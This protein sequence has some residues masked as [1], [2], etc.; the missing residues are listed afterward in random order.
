MEKVPLPGQVNLKVYLKTKLSLEKKIAPDVILDPFGLDVDD[1]VEL[2]EVEATDKTTFRELKHQLLTLGMLNH[3]HDIK[4]LR[5]S[6]LSEQ[7]MPMRIFKSETSTL[8]EG[9]LK[10][11][12]S[13]MVETLDSP[14]NIPEKST[15]F[16]V[17]RRVKQ[18]ETW[19]YVPL[20]PV[21]IFLKKDELTSVDKLKQ[22]LHAA[23]FAD[24]PLDKMILAHYLRRD[25]KWKVLNGP[26][27]N[28]KKQKKK[29]VSVEEIKQMGDR[30]VLAV[31]NKAEET[32]S[33]DFRTEY[34]RVQSNLQPPPESN[35]P[36]AEGPALTIDCDFD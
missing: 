21:E 15:L 10:H 9:K 34:D 4:Q 36:R 20:P 16:L 3:L 23:L 28:K 31:K 32:S 11:G 26:Q 2:G 33:D 14:E 12:D 7:K 13:I 29:P 1:L 35:K 25:F 8:K 19:H 27:N 22:Q 30:T 5:V 6:A 24:I 18:G 17:T